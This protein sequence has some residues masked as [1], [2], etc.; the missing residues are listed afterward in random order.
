MSCAKCGAEETIPD[1]R[2]SD[3]GHY[4]LDSNDMQ[5]TV[6]RNPDGVFKGKVTSEVRAVVCAS[7]G[8]IEMYVK[9]VLALRRA[10]EEAADRKRAGE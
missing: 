8:F 4:S 5:L 2:V 9:D 1:V 3:R 7:C 10:S 6:S